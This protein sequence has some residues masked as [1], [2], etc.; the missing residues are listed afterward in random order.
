MQDRP[1]KRPFC[2]AD[3][4][5]DDNRKLL[6]PHLY[7]PQGYRLAIIH[8]RA[9]VRSPSGLMSGLMSG[10]NSTNSTAKRQ[11]ATNPIQFQSPQSKR[12]TTTKIYIYMA[13]A[14]IQHMRLGL[15][16]QGA[17]QISTHSHGPHVQCQHHT[18]HSLACSRYCFQKSRGVRRICAHPTVPPAILLLAALASAPPAVCCVAVDR[19]VLVGCTAPS[20]QRAHVEA[21]AAGG[22]AESA[23]VDTKLCPARHPRTSS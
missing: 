10:L 13:G 12:T 8:Y 22:R 17:L 21:N 7:S 15:R 6:E 20:W 23:M 14:S 1:S 16:G 18:L 11:T 9:R 3:G 2:S 5:P 4:M 19:V